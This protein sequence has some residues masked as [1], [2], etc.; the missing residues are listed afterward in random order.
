MEFSDFRKFSPPVL[1]IGD[2][3]HFCLRPS[4]LHD[5]VSENLR[6]RFLLRKIIRSRIP[7]HFRQTVSEISW[8]KSMVYRQGLNE[9]YPEHLFKPQGRIAYARHKRGFGAYAM[10]PYRI[11]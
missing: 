9:G 2:K 5:A 6:E 8:R 11:V 10:R 3:M 4:A 1:Q 7:V